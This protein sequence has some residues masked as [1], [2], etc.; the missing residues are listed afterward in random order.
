MSLPSILNPAQFPVFNPEGVQFP[1]GPI[2]RPFTITP[3]DGTD[4]PTGTR[5]IYVGVAGDVSLLLLDNTTTV[6]LTLAAGWHPI[7]MK[8]VRSTGTTATGLIGGI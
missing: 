5:A 6:T 2:T 1:S 3:A 7:A 4:V 8:R